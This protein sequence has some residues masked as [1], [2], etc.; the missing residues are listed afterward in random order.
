[1]STPQQ[2]RRWGDNN[3][4]CQGCQDRC[5]GCHGQD[6]NGLYKCER[7]GQ[8][9]AQHDEELAT[10]REYVRTH[11]DVDAVLHGRKR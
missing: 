3:A 8:F 5:I 7:Y 11:D 4:P 1:M 6:A 9:K 2:F 10:R